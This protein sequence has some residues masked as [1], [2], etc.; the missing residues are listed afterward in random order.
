MSR[1]AFIN[2]A[3]GGPPKYRLTEICED[4]GIDLMTMLRLIRNNDGFPSPSLSFGANYTTKGMKD[5]YKTSY[6]SKKEVIDW[7]KKVT[8]EASK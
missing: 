2:S 5:V 7:Y 8:S 4:I 3:R 6:Y 1:K